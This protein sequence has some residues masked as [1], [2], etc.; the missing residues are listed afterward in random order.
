MDRVVGY[1]SGIEDAVLFA[2]DLRVYT[3]AKS[4]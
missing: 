3:L 1:Y 4:N 2:R